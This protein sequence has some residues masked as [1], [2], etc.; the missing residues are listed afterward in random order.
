MFL[1]T[2]ALPLTPL[3]CVRICPHRSDPPPSS[4][5]PLCTTPYTLFFDSVNLPN[6]LYYMLGSHC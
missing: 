5:R 6:M 3:P 2:S 4:G 1:R